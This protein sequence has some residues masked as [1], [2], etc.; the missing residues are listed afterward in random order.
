MVRAIRRPLA[1]FA[2]SALA[3]FAVSTATAPEAR[4]HHPW[5][6]QDQWVHMHTREFPVYREGISL[7]TAAAQMAEYSW[8]QNTDVRVFYTGSHWWSRI[9]IIPGNYG[10]TGWA[11]FASVEGPWDSTTG[12]Y[13]HSHNLYNHYYSSSSR[14]ALQLA[15]HEM[16][17]SLGLAHNWER[18]SCLTSRLGDGGATPNSHDRFQVRALYETYGH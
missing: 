13:N 3:A 10:D 1:A 9:H 7:W 16:G 17:H 15:C 8:S 18:D 4:A 2:V 11:G 12:H 14:H 5:I 6:H